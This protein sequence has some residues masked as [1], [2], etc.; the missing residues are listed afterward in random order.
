MQEKFHCEKS[1]HCI[2]RPRQADFE[3]PRSSGKLERIEH[4]H[5]AAIKIGGI[6]RHH[7]QPM[8]RSGGGQQSING[9]E[10]LP[11]AE[12]AP[13]LGYGLVHG[14]NTVGE[15][16]ANAF[17]P[18]IQSARRRGIF[19]T[20]GFNAAPQFSQCEHAQKQSVGRDGGKPG[21]YSRT[22]FGTAEFGQ[23]VR[24]YQ[25]AFHREISRGKSRC[26]SK[27][28]AGSLSEAGGIARR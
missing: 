5:A 22:P 12:S 8:H 18:A 19:E 17:H 20:Q 10:R 15:F 4:G 21:Q 1:L 16:R 24:V 11:D 6:T 3:T 25:I 9:R 7:S 28:S 13:L 2:P 14:K 26:R 27:R 23:D